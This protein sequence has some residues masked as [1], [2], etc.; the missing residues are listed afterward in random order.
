M[1][2]KVKENDLLI[3]SSLE[4]NLLQEL[5]DGTENNPFLVSDV[6]TFNSIRNN[7]S[8]CYRLTADIDFQDETITPM[9]TSTKAFRGEFDGDGY[10]ISNFSID[11]AASYAGL[12]G[13]AVT[14]KFK[15][16]KIERG[17]VK[18]LSGFYT[19]VLAGYI[20][21]CILD[22]IHLTDITISANQ[23]TGALT[24]YINNCT[25]KNI[26]LMDITV[27]GWNFVGALTGYAL[28]S[29]FTGCFVKGNNSVSGRLQVGGMIGRTEGSIT[30]VKEC[31]AVGNVEGDS[32]VGGLIGWMEGS[33]SDSFAMGSVNPATGGAFTGGLTGYALSCNIKN[34]FAACRMGQ[35][36]NGLANVGKDST[37]TNSYFNSDLAG[38]M[39]PEIQARTTE[40]M[41]RKETYAGWDLENIWENMEGSYPALKSLQIMEQEP[42]DLT[43]NNLTFFS[44]FIE[45]PEIPEAEEYDIS[46][47]N[48]TSSVT[49]PR[50][51]IEELASDT[52][53][54]F[55]VRAKINGITKAWSKVLKV[56]TKKRPSLDGLHSTGKGLNSITLIWNKVEDAEIYEVIYNN[57]IQKTKTNTCTITEL[58]TD[59]PYLIFVRVMMSDGSKIVSNR[60]IEKIYTLNPQTNYAEEF[61]TK[62]GGQ[63][64]F[65]DEIENLLSLKGKSI[66]TI[67]SQ[68][69]FATIYAIGLADRGVSGKIPAGIGELFQLQYLYLANNDLGGELPDELYA[70]DKLVEMDL[71]GNHF[72]D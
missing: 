6:E 5:G 22:N 59:T 11:S 68:K 4:L 60:I 17:K 32:I 41:A 45:W 29:T 9:G 14:A 58:N 12:F 7:L 62:C 10:S 52:D 2:E 61:I 39:T 63:T 31:G 57:C 35:L 54:E 15:N 65:M 71:S 3:K 24:G 46:Y 33:I 20:E 13:P 1:E 19:G 69:D 34:C 30:E 48:K 64:W 25:I 49:T 26:S 43:F 67:N 23:Y 8:A 55:R 38:I 50:I 72:S 53:Y 21:D 28:N 66:N 18:T 44:V 16:L 42:F 47:L 56:R 37:V 51:L 27:S 70:L 40:Q 36:S